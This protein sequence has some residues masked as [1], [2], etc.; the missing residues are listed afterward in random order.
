MLFRS[1]VGSASTIKLNSKEELR[2]DL[3]VSGIGI[4]PATAFL[5]KVSRGEDQSLAVDAAMRIIGASHIFAAGD[6]ANF[7]L[8]CNGGRVRIEH[9]R[10]AQEQA[11]TAAANMMG[12]EKTYSGVPYFW[13]YHYGVR[14]EFFGLRPDDSQLVIDGDLQEPRFVAA[15]VREGRCEGVFSAN[16]E[17]ETAKLFDQMESEG[18]PSLEAFHTVL[19]TKRAG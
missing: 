14:Y 6:V 8:P 9:W 10:V 3:V 19:S 1:K 12:L 2:A 17:S 13:T 7:P 15:Y 5:K 16:R 18:P 11:R 4:E